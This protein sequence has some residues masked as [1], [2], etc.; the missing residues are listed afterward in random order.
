METTRRQNE[1]FSL[2]IKSK[3]TAESCTGLTPVMEYLTG[4]ISS[5]GVF[6]ETSRPLPIASR[7][8]LE[9]CLS[10]DDLNKLRFILSLEAL[11]SW[12]EERMWV[13]A[14]GIV[15]RVEER[16]MAVIFDQ[17]YQLSPLEVLA[18]PHND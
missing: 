4:N 13:K 5:G 12:K 14:S 3:V 11:R 15:I 9:L 8:R 1:R 7:V 17:N 10:Q 2:K 6:L 18:A 16:G